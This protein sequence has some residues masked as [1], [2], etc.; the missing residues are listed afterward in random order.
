VYAPSPP[1]VGGHSGSEVAMPFAFDGTR[2]RVVDLSLRVQAPGTAD[3]PLQARRGFLADDSFKHEVTTHTHVGTHIESP[4]HFFDGGRELG[5]YPLDR[6]YGPAVLFDFRGVDG[7]QID[8]GALQQGIGDIMRPG[9]I[10]VCRNS[11]PDW[12]AVAAQ[13]RS[14][15]PYL[16]AD[17]ARWLADRQ[18]RLL[19]IDDFTGIR[20]ANGKDISRQ[21]HAILLAPGVEIPILEFADGVEQLT[22][23]EFFFMALPVRFAGLDSVW[24]RAIAV[25]ER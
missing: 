18:A 11:H 3:R 15:I 5:D 14:R 21:N 8:S 1:A 24:T 4:A 2:Y 17:G 20:L 25:E 19:V 22:K 7:E 13:N 10:V 9:R 23:R 12:R 6:F 16:V